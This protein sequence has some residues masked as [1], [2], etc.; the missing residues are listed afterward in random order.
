MKTIYQLS[1]IASRLRDATEV[2]SIGP[3]E[4]F[5]LQADVLEY[6]AGME[7]NENSLGLRKVYKS[8]DL[9][10][11][12]SNA[13]VGSNGKELRF[14]QLV[15]VFDPSN[16]TQAENGNVYAYQKGNTGA[17]AWS[18]T[19]NL[20]A[21][22]SEELRILE[23]L[24]KN[25]PRIETSE[26]ADFSIYDEQ[27]NA[28]AEFSNGHIKTKN[29]DSSQAVTK[30]DIPDKNRLPEVVDDTSTDF[31]VK[32]ADGNVI[33]RVKGG[34]IKT[35]NF[36]SRMVTPAKP[37]IYC[38]GSSMTQ[39]QSGIDN[40]I[41]DNTSSAAQ[42]C[43]PN[44]LQDF[45]GNNYKV[46]NLGVGGQ[47]AGE[48]LARNGLLDGIVKTQFTLKGDGTTSVLCSGSQSATVADGVIVDSCAGEPINY[49]MQQGTEEAITQMAR[50]YINGIQC[51]LSYNSS[52]GNL[53]IKRNDA[54]N[55]DLT[56]PV[57]AHITFG[58]NKIGDD[59][60]YIVQVGANDLAKS[61]MDIDKYIAKV[62]QG[63][64]RLDTNRWIS[65]GVYRGDTTYQSNVNAINSKLS[66]EFGSRFINVLD[67]I[68]SLQPF[69]ELGITPTTDND[70]SAE[71]AEHGIV[72]DTYCIANHLTP[73][74]FWR[75][76][77]TPNHKELDGKPLVD[78]VH[79][80]YNGYSLVAKLIFDKMKQLN[81]I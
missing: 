7:R 61:N 75:Y 52:D 36:D 46:I 32:D 22:V 24:V 44:R 80:N 68:S 70:I 48:I 26:K 57:G 1:Q 58:G 5:G 27:Y 47:K 55:Y 79:L 29:F 50:C 19:G 2:G 72:S 73:S 3:Q 16:P 56:I 41:D 33:L 28:I 63:I 14:G 21:L 45:V 60:I 8:Y 39:G 65:V 40:P 12:D 49:Q 18:L 13:P 69:Y 34:H 25:T 77:Y 59:A 74:S 30:N 35:K 15:S 43:Y 71:R 62:K 66:E 54:V 11:A 78:K 38:L 42:N 31:S 6:I 20:A 67:Y 81:Y 10:L 23:E 37:Y 4:T 9:M 51:T 76:S 17:A 53:Y 64:S